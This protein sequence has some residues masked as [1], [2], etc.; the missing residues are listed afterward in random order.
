M[1]W[2]MS[3]LLS[4]V[5]NGTS[6]L[7]APPFETV[8]LCSIMFKR[9]RY[10]PFGFLPVLPAGI[11]GSNQNVRAN[12]GFNPLDTLKG[13]ECS[14]THGHIRRVV[15]T[16]DT[17]CTPPRAEDDS[18]HV[19]SDGVALAKY[20]RK[21]MPV[22]RNV[23]K[24]SA[25]TVADVAMVPSLKRQALADLD[26][27]MY[28]STSRA[29]RDAL[30]QTWDKFHLM[31]YGPGVPSI[32]LDEA[33]LLHV[34]SLFKAGGYKS[35][36]NYLSRI[37]ERH[38]MEGHQ[39]SD[40]LSLIAARCARSVL[41]GLA[42]QTRS[43][44]FDW[45]KVFERMAQH[46][47]PLCDH[48][49]VHPFPMIV[50]ATYF[51]LRE[52]EASAIDVED[53][54]FTSDSVTLS[55]PVSKTDWAAKGCRRTWSCICN[56]GLVCPFHVIKTH[57]D[58]M[59]NKGSTGPL[60]PSTL[61]TYC[62]KSGVVQ[63]IRMATKLSGAPCVNGSGEWTV[64]GHTFRITGARMLSTAGLDPITVQLLGR[65]GSNAV[66]S[67]IAESPLNSVSDRLSNPLASQTIKSYTS[68][69]TQLRPTELD[70]KAHVR[71]A[72]EELKQFKTDRCQF[73]KT[74]DTINRRLEDVQDQLDGMGVVLDQT[75]R[76]ETWDVFNSISQ[77]K[78]RSL[79]DLSLAPAAWQTAC[80]WKF[81]GKQHVE[82]GRCG[83][84]NKGHVCPKCFPSDVSPED[85][86]SSGS[87]S[88]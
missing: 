3:V 50:T 53:V 73:I 35:F 23:S 69:S 41:R 39:W 4:Q 74:L 58:S 86:S 60:F 64:S 40:R 65:W 12:H 70:D 85:S 72:L 77:V 78:H 30:L 83:T 20:K 79:V 71:Q 9:R 26:R 36:R 63:T 82:T 59:A 44:A 11:V 47:V 48:G 57:W 18:N 10:S 15:A 84:I 13:G 87:S 34:S 46:N 25:S 5:H 56:K 16:L 80:G 43:D 32:P 33:K 54:S 17:S 76:V 52:L 31:W 6:F 55:L 2:L 22:V 61:G 21:D 88:D 24:A 66:L 29:P 14:G 81:A 68:G 19:C 28:A 42:G 51:M 75:N 37:K 67:Y 62:T 27:D 49:P 8:Y 45:K 1:P 7:Q 38:I